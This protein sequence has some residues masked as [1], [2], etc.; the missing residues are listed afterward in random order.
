[1]Q[2]KSIKALTTRD[3][4]STYIFCIKSKCTQDESANEKRTEMTFM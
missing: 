1:M 4:V 3:T 2:F